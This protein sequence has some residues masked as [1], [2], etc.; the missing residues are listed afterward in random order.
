MDSHGEFFLYFIG[1]INDRLAGEPPQ[2]IRAYT[3][4]IIKH[5]LGMPDQKTAIICA[6]LF[7]VSN[8]AGP[9]DVRCVE[10]SVTHYQLAL[11]TK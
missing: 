10:V 5:P 11:P 9:K 1:K 8:R 2:A 7:P 3:A 4:F 6:V